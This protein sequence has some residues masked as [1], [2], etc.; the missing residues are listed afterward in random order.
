M[1]ARIPPSV[2]AYVRLSVTYRRAMLHRRL[3]SWQD[4][5][6]G[7]VLDI[8]GEKD[9]LVAFQFG[10]QRGVEACIFLNI[11]SAKRPDVVSD[12]GHI[13]FAT[14]TIDTVVCLETLEHVDDPLQVTRELARVLHPSGVLFLSV[15]FL[16][17]LHDAPNDFWRF[18]QYQVERMLRQ[19]GLEIVHMEHLGLVLTVLCDITK[20]AISGIRW[21]ALRWTLGLFFLP[22]SAL[23]I[24]LENLWKSRHSH[25]VASFTTGYLVMARKLPTPSRDGQGPTSPID[26]RE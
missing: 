18:T 26:E 12:G 2:A 4:Y 9:S 1:S 15:P 21:A 7:I 8:G 24:N 13:P 17:R 3:L 6:Q 5:V 14:G 25:A 23:A 10:R 22:A 20:Q 11:R 19:A 16:Y